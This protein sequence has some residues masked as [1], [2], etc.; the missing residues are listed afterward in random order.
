MHFLLYAL[1]MI[2]AFSSPSF[3]GR[4]E[5]PQCAADLIRANELVESVAARTSSYS[6][7][8]TARVCALLRSNRAEIQ[9][10]TEIEIMRRCLT[11]HDR[12]ENVAQMAASL[13]DIDAVLA[14]KC[15]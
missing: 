3:A 14:V 10:S 15:R 13:E 8:E 2:G 6:G 1:A 9:L 11:G 4:V 12:G 7:N 5:T